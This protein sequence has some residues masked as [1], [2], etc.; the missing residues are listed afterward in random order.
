MDRRESLKTLLIG[1]VA[2]GALATGV[3][4]Q[5]N[6][7]QKEESPEMEIGGYGRTP[8]EKARD[9]ALMSET[10]FSEHELATIAILCDILLPKDEISGAATEAG[11]PEFIEF[12]AKDIPQHQL[13]LRGG[14]MW[15]DHESNSRF[16]KVFKDLSDKEQIAIVDDIAYPEKAEEDPKLAQ[17]VQFFD[18]MRNLTVTGFYTTKM[19]LEALGYVGNRPNIWDGIPEDVLAEHDV[20]YDEEWLSKCI[21]QSKREEIAEWDDEGN[22]VT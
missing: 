8:E 7:E 18:R 6:T 19:G 22:L 14:I 12:I 4:C 3:G 21:D 5:P 20:D 10:F 9:K 2:G 15:L 16:G 1:T 11:V 13:P 17:G